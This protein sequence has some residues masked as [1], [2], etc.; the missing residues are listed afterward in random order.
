MKKLFRKGD[1]IILALG[2][3]L[4]ALTGCNSSKEAGE[5]GA[6]TL[7]Y[8]DLSGVNTAIKRKSDLYKKYMELCGVDFTCLIA[9]GGQ[10][11]TKLQ[12]YFN[13]GNL[14]DMFISRTAET[15][16]LF[17][18]MI[19]AEALLPISDYVS[20]KEYPNIY[21]Q[22]QKYSFLSKN[23]DFMNGKMYMIPTVWTQEHTMFIRM[24]WIENLNKKLASILV[25]DGVIS[26]E[27]SMTDAIYETYKFTV[28]QDLMEFYRLCRA[29]TLYDPDGNG[30]DDTYGYTSTV[31]MYSDNWLYVAGGGYRIMEDNNKDGKY[32]FSGTSDGNKYIVNFVN[33]LLTNGFMD[34]SWATNDASDKLA[35]FGNGQ[36]GIIENQAMLNLVLSYFV[37]QKNWSYEEAA[38]KIAMFA[39][40]KGIDGEYGIQG[41]PNF[42]TSVCL[43][44]DMS[45]KKRGDALKLMDWLLSDEAVDLLTY[46]VEGIHYKKSEN[47]EKTVRESLMGAQEGEHPVNWTIDGK[48]T[49]SAL[50]LFTNITSNY[51]NEMQTNSGKIIEAMEKAK[52]Y[53]RY[54][55]YYMLTE[56]TYTE[57]FEGLCDKMQTEFTLMERNTS[58]ASAKPD[59]TKTSDTWWDT[60][61]QY[62]EPFNSAWSSYVKTMNTTYKGDAITTAYNAALKNGQLVKAPEIGSDGRLVFD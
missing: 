59:F 38:E 2:M 39:P 50:R 32:E 24:D 40:P 8:S 17:N 5:D 25:K 18:K 35:A 41:H 47:N 10:A 28:P 13:T 37:T 23:I 20:E 22:L 62:S 6:L 43:S 19:K 49:F 54:P 21:R 53:N 60:F 12:Q 42:W 57:Y 52:T 14:P 48:D 11:D 30:K 46:G 45:E 16:V 31:D 44:A 55:D 3:C 29:F 61:K 26:N 7:F 9:G 56:K 27:I 15:P 51:Y 36:V 1:A 33:N 4:T 34:P 58:Y